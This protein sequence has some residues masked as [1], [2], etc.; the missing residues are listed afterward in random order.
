MYQ[1][2]YINFKILRTFV[3]DY[4]G[5]PLRSHERGTTYVSVELCGCSGARTVDFGTGN[6]LLLVLSSSVFGDDTKNS[7]T[8]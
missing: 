3:W 8:V 4:Y 7:N 1:R 2:T 6:R 5:E